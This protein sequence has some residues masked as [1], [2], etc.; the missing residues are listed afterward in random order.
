MSKMLPHHMTHIVFQ[1]L[2]TSSCTDFNDF[3]K[4]QY[5]QE[6]KNWRISSKALATMVEELLD[7]AEH[8]YCTLLE[9]GNW[10]RSL[11][12]QSG[13]TYH[14][15]GKEKEEKDLAANA[16]EKGRHKYI[17]PWK[18]PPQGNKPHEQMFKGKKEFWCAWGCHWNRYH[19]TADHKTRK[20]LAQL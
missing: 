5:A 18:P 6:A 20:E 2:K 13:S 12:D 7:L 9:E 8:K 3:F 15:E 17:P 4:Y 1:L 19:K 11:S 10:T 14:V 16:V